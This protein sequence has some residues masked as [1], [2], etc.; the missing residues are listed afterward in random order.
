MSGLVVKPWKIGVRCSFDSGSHLHISFMLQ[1]LCSVLLERDGSVMGHPYCSGCM[2]S[3]AYPLV[4]CFANGASVCFFSISQLIFP[5][6]NQSAELG[7]FW[8]I[9][10][11]LPQPTQNPSKEHSWRSIYQWQNKS[12]PFFSIQ[13]SDLPRTCFYLHSQLLPPL[14]TKP[15]IPEN[16]TTRPHSHAANITNLGL[17]DVCALFCS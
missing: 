6:G 1:D 11:Y 14:S 10:A 17:L 15:A 12:H 5:N 2:A 16:S 9:L 7:H 13:L 4:Q 8:C 3:S